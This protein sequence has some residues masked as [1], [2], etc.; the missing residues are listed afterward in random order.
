M[1]SL[2]I[3]VPEI[4]KEEL[5]TALFNAGA[6]RLGAYRACSWE[7]LGTGQFRPIAGAKPHIGALNMLE[8]VQEYRIEMLVEESIWPTV[9]DTLYRTHPYEEPA[10]YLTQILDVDC[11]TQTH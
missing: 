7:V 4:N 10:F 9:R 8:T 2:V 5:K 3:F 11:Q 6:G 1:Y